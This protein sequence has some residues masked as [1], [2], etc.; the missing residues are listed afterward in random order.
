MVVGRAHAQQMDVG[1]QRAWH[2]ELQR[3][4]T[5]KLDAPSWLWSSIVELVASHEA[6][7]LEHCR[8][9][10]LDVARTKDADEKIAT[11]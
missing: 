2:R 8:R 9:H 6:G 1:A 5:A 11:A 7:Y 4:R 3:N 10:A